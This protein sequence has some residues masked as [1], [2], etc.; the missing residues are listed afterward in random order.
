VLE[1]L[2]LPEVQKFINDHEH[3]DE[4]ELV[5]KHKEILGVPSPVIAAQIAGR[6]KAK[7]KLPRYYQTPGI[8]FPPAVN[9]EQSSSEQT[10]RFKSTI[11]PEALPAPNS[12]I[13]QDGTS[14][15]GIGVDLTS[16][17]GVDTYFLSKVFT[18]MD[19][20]EPDSGLFEIARHNHKQLG[21]ENIR[22]HNVTAETFLSR[23]C[24]K[25]DLIFI[26]PSRRPG[27]KKVFTLKDSEPDIIALQSQIFE[28]TCYLLIKAAPLLDISMALKELTFVKSVF[29][30]ATDNEVKELLFLAEKNFR[31]E[32]VINCINLTKRGRDSFS[33]SF[34][35]EAAAET[36]F[37]DPLT[38]LYEPNAAILKGGAFRSVSE[39][40]KVA[41]IQPSTHLYTSDN[42]IEDFPGRTFRIEARVKPGKSLRQFFP[43]GKAN[44]TTRNYPLSVEELKKKTGLKDGGEKFLIGFSGLKEK[45]LVVAGRIK[46]S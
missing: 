32:P 26:D 41:K 9:L 28:K 20:V 12:E 37:S 15:Y 23:H 44:I 45:F 10:A 38:Y 30:V 25:A 3:D 27:N 35:E 21:A 16:G 6:R 24:E 7:E 13:V 14:G 18:Q 2:L 46:R 8:I 19:Y 22:H 29:V 17:L 5:L 1:N 11:I 43:E 36:R 42:L 39:N 34:T 40:F 33:F 4:R 31:D